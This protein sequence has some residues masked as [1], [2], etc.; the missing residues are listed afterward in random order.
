MNRYLFYSLCFLLL[1]AGTFA[2]LN[3]A[4]APRSYQLPRVRQFDAE[5]TK[6]EHRDLKEFTK[7]ND[8]HA[9]AKALRSHAARQHIGLDRRKSDGSDAYSASSSAKPRSACKTCIRLFNGMEIQPSPGIEP[10]LLQTQKKLSAKPGKNAEPLV[11]IIQFKGEL[12]ISELIDLLDSGVKLH[13]SIGEATFLARLPL[14]AVPLLQT[15]PYVRWIGEY[16][17]EYKYQESALVLPNNRP[18]AVIYSLDG[19]RPEFRTDLARLDIP[20][21]AYDEVTQSYAVTLE[22]GRIPETAEQLCWA[23]GIDKPRD[24]RLLSLNYQPADS[25]MLIGCFDTQCNGAGVRVGVYDS[26]I[27][28]GNTLDFPAGSCFPWQ[29]KF[30]D[31]DGHGTHVCG[32]I[33]ARGGRAIEGP[34]AG[35]GAAAGANLYI[36]PTNALY[37]LSDVFNYFNANQVH[38]SNHSWGYYYSDKTGKHSDYTHNLGTT[39]FDAYADGK[40][41]VIVVAA[42]ND[43]SARTINNPAT[44]KNVIAVGAL[45]YATDDAIPGR[46]IGARA[47][48]SSCGPTRDDGRLKPELVAPGGQLERQNGIVSTNNTDWADD[49]SLIWPTSPWYTR[50]S[51]TSMAAPHVTGVCA[52]IAQ[53]QGAVHSEVMKALLINTAL[54]LKGNT[55]DPLAGFATTELGYGMVN[56]FSATEFYPGEDEP[57]LILQDNVKEYD[58]VHEH[59]FTVAPGARQLRVTLAYNDISKIQSNA[60]LLWDDLDL[61]LVAP[62][63]A[64]YRASEHLASGVTAQSPLE[65]MV[66]ENPA[67]G[68]WKARVEFVSSPDFL[69]PTT[70]A[71]ETFGLV[72]DVLYKSPALS[73]TLPQ[74]HIQVKPG[75]TFQLQPTIANSGGSIAAGVTYHVAAQPDSGFGGDVNT[76]HYLRNLNFQGDAVAPLISIEAP[77]AP[78]DYSLTIKADGINRELAGA[79]YPRTRN[80][81]VTVEAPPPAANTSVAASLK[82]SAVGDWRQYQ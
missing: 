27:F 56:A 72:A 63:G 67:A 73:L 69:N 14:S 26:G 57:A 44:G 28:G 2:Q 3:A 13:E 17:A 36:A 82:V 6:P 65:K 50:M 10:N 30:S 74:A 15:K 64:A 52:Q 54:P 80:V 4:P 43:A 23:K 7:M 71:Q 49:G 38:I 46:V 22:A 19:D 25:R 77:A 39:M 9:T 61:V 40:G 76:T 45:N 68:T 5:T 53:N 20:V 58:R 11:A 18:D 33:A 62:D 79:E 8:P 78:G 48:Y 81:T 47:D 16:R 21:H 32:I 66:I 42:G 29:N 35:R 34:C 59:G 41:M 60:K 31:A 37:A 75:Q 55:G 51:G 12:T 24:I 1:P 70:V